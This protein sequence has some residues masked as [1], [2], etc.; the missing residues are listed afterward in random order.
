MTYIFVLCILCLAMLFNS[1]FFRSSSIAFKPNL[2]LLLPFAS[3][4]SLGDSRAGSSLSQDIATPMARSYH[5]RID[6]L[7]LGM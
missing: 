6:N 7:I 1:V 2:F 5:N 3:L 4:H